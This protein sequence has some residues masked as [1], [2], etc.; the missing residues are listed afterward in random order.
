MAWVLFMV[1]SL[2]VNGPRPVVVGSPGDIGQSTRR[3]STSSSVQ[4]ARCGASGSGPGSGPSSAAVAPVDPGAGPSLVRVESVS[5]YPPL[6]AGPALALAAA[7]VASVHGGCPA[8]VVAER[9]DE[10]RFPHC[11]AWSS[12]GRTPRCCPPKASMPNFTG[13]RQPRT[14]SA[15]SSDSNHPQSKRLSKG[16]IT[17]MTCCSG[18]ALPWRM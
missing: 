14:A 12:R 2:R 16:S 17:S 9:F 5:R 8:R 4:I 13:S 10:R 18:F 3:R 1:I 15:H 7:S 11:A 6:P